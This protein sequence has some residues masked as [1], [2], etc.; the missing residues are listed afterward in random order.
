MRRPKSGVREALGEAILQLVDL[1]GWCVAV[2]DPRTLD[3]VSEAEVVGSWSVVLGP[4]ALGLG[5][6][7]VEE[8]LV[9][10]HENKEGTA[11]RK[12]WASLM[13]SLG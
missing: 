10:L 6:W 2:R 12:H 7:A 3:L 9:T 13:F 5:P 8:P 1:L 4:W 11:C